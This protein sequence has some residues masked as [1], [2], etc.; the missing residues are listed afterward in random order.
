[1]VS[2]ERHRCFFTLDE[3]VYLKQH[4]TFSIL[5]TMIGRTIPF[6]MNSVCTRKKCARFSCFSQTWFCFRRYCC[7][8][9]SAELSNLEQTEPISTL[10]H[11]S[12][13]KYSFQEL[14]QFSPG[15]NMLHAPASNI[16][17]LHYRDTC[18]SSTLLSRNLWEKI[19]LSQLWYLWFA[20]RIPVKN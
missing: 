13:R 2:L 3:W 11:L 12:S 10:I 4:E 19:T 18:V 6:K 15:N 8:V 16:D 5:K 9:N 17:C 20:G 7:F 1:M 14:T